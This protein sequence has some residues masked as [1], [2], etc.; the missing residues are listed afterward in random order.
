MLALVWT[1]VFVPSVANVVNLRREANALI[2]RADQA[3]Y[4]AK[5][6]GRNRV[7]IR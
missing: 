3:M 1:L 2:R 5:R 7:E 6:C 4:A